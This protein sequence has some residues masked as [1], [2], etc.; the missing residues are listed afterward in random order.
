MR[1]APG[2]HEDASDLASA[3]D[4]TRPAPPPGQREFPAPPPVAPPP[5]A[6]S[7]IT[8]ILARIGRFIVLEPLGEGGMGFVYAAYD[9]TLDRKIA[10]KVLRP[11]SADKPAATREHLLREAQAMARVSHSNIVTV[12]EIGSVDDQVFIAMEFIRGRTLAAWISTGPHPWRETVERL[13]HAGRGLAAAHAAGLV[14]GDFKPANVMLGDNGAV[15]VLDFGLARLHEPHEAHAFADR[16]TTDEP[17][18]G[19]PAYMAPELLRGEPATQRSDQFSYCVSL[20]EALYAQDPFASE[21]EVL[22]GQ[23][24]EPPTSVV[25]PAALLRI[26]RRGL[27]LDPA[28][29]F[30]S[31]P[32]L[33]AALEATL[34]RRRR[35][36]LVPVGVA[37]LGGLALAFSSLAP[38]QDVCGAASREI[39]DLWNTSEAEVVHARLLA[40]GLAYAEDTWTRVHP[41]LDAYA[42]A[43]VDRRIA[44]CT[45][46]RDGALAPALFDLRTACLDQR[47]ASLAAFVR[48]LEMGDTD[49]VRNAT[50]AAAALPA[51]AACDDAQALTD[52]VAPHG[53]PALAARVARARELLAEAQAQELTGQFAR[54]LAVVTAID[55]AAVPHPPLLAEIGLRR[56]SLQSELGHHQAADAGLM[57]ALR[58]ALTSG[59]YLAAAAIATRRDFIR[60]ARLQRPGEVLEDSALV[61]GLVT[62]AALYSEGAAYRGDHVNNLGIA[63]SLLG[64][65]AA[66]QRH[67]AEALALRREALGADHPQ[68]VYAMS[69]LALSYIETS[70]L[71]QAIGLLQTALH[72]AETSLGPGHPH[73]ALLAINL[74]YAHRTLGQNRAATIYLNR[75]L[76]L[77]TEQLGADSPDLHY[78]LETLGAIALEQRRCDQAAQYYQRALHLLETGGQPD[79]AS[80][81]LRGLGQAAACNGDFPAA[82]AHMQRAQTLAVANHGADELPAARLLYYIGEVLLQS[83]QLDQA[84]ASY[85]RADDILRAKLAP[86]SELAESQRRIG[87]AHLRRH[88]LVAGTAAAQAALKIYAEAGVVDSLSSAMVHALLGRLALEGGDATLAWQHFHSSATLYAASVDPE[89]ADLALVRFGM[90]RALAMKSGARTPEARA[91][92]EQALTVLQDVAREYPDELREVRAWLAAR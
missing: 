15:K 90:A 68:V 84:L 70:D 73:I 9:E 35:L 21:V 25:V 43:L 78:V 13:L 76:E 60:A 4:V 69:N 48:I 62:R 74:G 10:I 80:D 36:G 47:H 49:V 52:V 1:V 28:R 64:H 2:T 85:T 39:T 72:T 41:R 86:A 83:G 50:A 16:D 3:L 63:E 20:Y 44:A 18:S 14:H 29:R 55:L 31:M 33:L 24:A 26:I 77:Q 58:L 5:L 45:A 75:A 67:F 57:E 87:E 8:P 22:A 54:G 61:E 56:A 92:A 66:A 34:R 7:G 59:H 11:E 46:H 42:E 40:T 53:D 32:A 65:Q 17:T 37:L 88:D 12:H 81:A 27:A 79:A 23:I 6:S 30:P 89:H 71:D 82:L 38:T 51:V 91:L 19:T